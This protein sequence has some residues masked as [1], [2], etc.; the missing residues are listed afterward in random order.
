M[1]QLRRLCWGL[2]IASFLNLSLSSCKSGPKDS[3]L[4]TQAQ[5]KLPTGISIDVKNGIVTISGEF[6]DD[7]AKQ[8]TENSLKVIPGIKSIIDQTTVKP[9]EFPMD[10]ELTTK[11][12]AVIKDYTGVLANVKDGVIT[13]NGQLNRADLPKLMQAINALQPKKIEQ[14]LTLK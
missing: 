3:E 11:V 7:L 1:K 4:K 9:V 8:S 14:K 6:S 5:A 10:N 13:L 2:A 12:N